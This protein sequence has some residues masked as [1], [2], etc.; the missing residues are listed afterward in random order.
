MGVSKVRPPGLIN[1]SGLYTV[2]IN[3]LDGNEAKVAKNLSDPVYVV[4][5]YG[6]DFVY[7]IKYIC[8]VNA[9]ILFLTIK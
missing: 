4:S 1:G 2:M 8:L 6:P 3:C 9:N 7:F 5:K